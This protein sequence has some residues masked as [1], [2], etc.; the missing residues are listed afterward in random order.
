MTSLITHQVLDAEE[1]LRLIK[2]EGQPMTADQVAK[3]IGRDASNTR[4]SLQAWDK[5]GL[6]KAETV[7]RSTVYGM[8]AAG[9]A[10]LAALDGQA[11]VAGMPL[12][13]LAQIEF[14]PDNPRK[15]VAQEPLEGLADTIAEAEGLLQPIVLYPAGA[16]GVRM[17]HAGERRVRACRLLQSEGRLPPAL[18]EGLPFIER[19]AT[20]A[21]ALFIGLVENSQRENLTPFEDALALKAF[22][23]ETGLSARAIAF[24]LGRAREG[25]EVG[26][27]DVQE[28]IR[29]VTK[30]SAENQARVA[31]GKE[32]FDWLKAT[33]R[34]PAEEI[35][36]QLRAIDLM[37]LGEVMHKGKA[38][39]KNRHWGS[40]TEVSYKAGADP[41]VKGLISQGLLTFTEKDY[42]DH[43]AYIDIG[44]AARELSNSEELSPTRRQDREGEA[45]LHRLR[46]A[47]VGEEA[48]KRAA[49]NGAYVTAW[50]NGPFEYSKTA[51]A[52]IAAAKLTKSELRT[53]TKAKRD[54]DDKRF[55]EV[56][57]LRE[58]VEAA[59]WNGMSGSKRSDAVDRML[60]EFKRA[61]LNFPV[62]VSGRHIVDDN[63]VTVFMNIGWQFASDEAVILQLI[64]MALNFACA[65]PT[66]YE[67]L[68]KKAA[69]K[70]VTPLEDAIARVAA[71][72]REDFVG[73]IG[74][75]LVRDHQWPAATASAAAEE[76]L[77]ADLESNAM[78]YGDPAQH[79]DE[80]VADII[81]DNWAFLRDPPEAQPAS[82]TVNQSQGEDHAA[83]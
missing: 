32:S 53:A 16:N 35:A 66:T 49:A 43:K 50:L 73:L 18:A 56:M 9:E 81:A 36:G 83:A 22:Q 41:L 64:C 79:W 72:S 37:V 70:E 1:M 10:A 40:E 27:R 47:A 30:T 21:E 34:K 46:V 74:V 61:K 55:Q 77:A 45:A 3:A 76:A 38:K 6:L 7:G 71:D 15:A 57:A 26:V 42:S 11:G 58:I 54:A 20:K 69:P 68:G 44:Q 65:P 19:A 75:A 67:D 63:G 82:L 17:L 13:P 52:A 60:S 4:K 31:A 28:K 51:E 24:K 25:F 8:T 48:A 39:P 2:A 78:E 14:N 29:V 62:R 80:K 59:A 5:A 12:W 33:T 23:K